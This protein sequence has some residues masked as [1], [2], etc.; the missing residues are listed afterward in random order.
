MEAFLI[1]EHT[2]IPP[3]MTCAAYRRSNLHTTQRRPSWTAKVR[4]VLSG[5]ALRTARQGSTC[6]FC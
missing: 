3:G 2:D 6:P 1:Y 4:R 5:R